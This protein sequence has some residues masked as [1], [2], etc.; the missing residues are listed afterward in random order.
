MTK[1]EKDALIESAMNALNKMQTRAEKA[2]KD[3][4]EIFS[5]VPPLERFFYR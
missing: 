2:K 1:T 3:C 4:K 5:K